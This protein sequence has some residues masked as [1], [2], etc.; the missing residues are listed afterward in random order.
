MASPPSERVTG[1]SSKM[2]PAANMGIS[3]EESDKNAGSAESDDNT[4]PFT[5]TI[6]TNVFRHLS[7]EYDDDDDDDATFDDD[8]DAGGGGGDDNDEGAATERIAINFYESWLRNATND[9]SFPE[10]RLEWPSVGE[11]GGFLGEGVFHGGGGDGNGSGVVATT[12]S[13]PP[14]RAW[15]ENDYSL[16]PDYGVPE[17]M[18]Y[19]VFSMLILIFILGLICNVR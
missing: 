9:L 4:F 1:N 2:P 18:H 16:R 13:P 11:G 15:W 12:A 3:S 14:A 8:D 19:V 7:N 17:W 5:T 10:K 6:K